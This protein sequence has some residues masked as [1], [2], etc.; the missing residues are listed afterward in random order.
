VRLRAVRVRDGQG[1]VSDTVDIRQPVTIEIEYEVLRPGKRLSP[2]ILCKNEEG[3][4]IFSSADISREA[5]YNQDPNATGRFWS[6]CTVPGNILAEGALTVSVSIYAMLDGVQSHAH[7]HDAVRFL[8]VDSIEGDS[9]RGV[10][11][12]QVAGVIR[13]LLPWTTKLVKA[14]S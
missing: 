9:A 7:E 11:A 3:L 2:G 1:E 6:S 14:H 4:C 13:P 5:V 10:Y 8:V 12:G